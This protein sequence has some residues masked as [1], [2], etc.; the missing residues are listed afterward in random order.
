MFE[1][2]GITFHGYGLLLGMAVWLAMEVAVSK[3]N[4][5]NPT[6]LEK[7]MWWVIAG[8]VIGARVYHVIDLWQ[9][10]YSIYPE[11]IF[12]LWEGG[13]GIWGAI[14]GGLLTLSIY[15]FFNKVKFLSYLDSMIVGVPL[16]QAIGRVGNF[17]NGELYGKNGEPL[18]AY[19]GVLDMILFFGL[20]ITS[21]KPRKS[22]FVSGIYLTGYGLIR[23]ALENFRPNDI[24]WKFAGM[25]MAIWFG[26]LAIL[27]GVYLIFRQ[28][29]S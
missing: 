12:Y 19:E 21:S 17:V 3:R 27:T 8:G 29:R 9:N 18:F 15:C 1:F 26:A 16:A 25:P 10:Y 2:S 11:K 14:T 22:G 20:M 23:I 4:S 5:L 24:I 28:R 6:S 13:L 7:A